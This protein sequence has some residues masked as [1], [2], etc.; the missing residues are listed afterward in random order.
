MTGPKQ[1]TWALALTVVVTVA[2]PAAAPPAARKAT[3]MASLRPGRPQRESEAAVVSAC[4]AAG[5]EGPSFWPWVMTGPASAFPAPFASL[6][7]Y[8]HLNRTMRAGEVARVD[9]GCDNVH[10]QGD[11]GR[12]APVSGTFDAG[13]RETWELLI[14][15][16]RSGLAEFRDGARRDDIFAASLAEVR[17]RQPALA[18]PLGKKAAEALLGAD[19]LKWWEIHGVGLEAAEGT[20]EILRAGMVVAFEPIFSVEGQGFYLEDMSGR[21]SR[22]TPRLPTFLYGVWLFRSR[23]EMFGGS[24]IGTWLP[25]TR[26]SGYPGN[27]IVWKLKRPGSKI[28]A[29]SGAFRRTWS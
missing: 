26:G 27:R 15:A 14:A 13:Q 17:R 1:G 25:P 7:D 28:V 5:A 11:V 12:T 9:V 29:S 20:P 8:R 3:H 4:I 22:C 6:L 10:Y 2:T 23:I 19:G 16:Y 24:G 18:T 21:S